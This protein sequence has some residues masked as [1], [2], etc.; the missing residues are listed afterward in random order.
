MV[1]KI[2]PLPPPSHTQ[3]NKEGSCEHCDEIKGLGNY[4]QIKDRSGKPI[5]RKDIQEQYMD[6]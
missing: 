3:K 2:N 4:L 6:R 1:D 5:E